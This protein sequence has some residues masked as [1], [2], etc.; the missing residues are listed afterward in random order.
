MLTVYP[1]DY[2]PHHDYPSEPIGEGNP[3][4][5][6]C[7]CG[8]SDPQINGTLSGHKG[9]C[10]WVAGFQK[11][12]Q[13]RYY[14]SMIDCAAI[15]G[16]DG[17]VWTG[18]R[19]YHCINTIIQATG[20]KQVAEGYEQGFVTMSGRFVTRREAG[21]LVQKTGQVKVTPYNPKLELFSENLY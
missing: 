19:H 20:V 14:D 7:S 13:E 1:P 8:A 18:K 15:R 16:P 10:G 21:Q 5:Q 2:G 17:R 4:Y 3:Y 12:W 11:G 9:G 6:C